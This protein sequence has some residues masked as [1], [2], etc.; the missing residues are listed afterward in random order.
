[1]PQRSAE[2]W[3]RIRAD[4]EAGR[5]TIAAIAAREGV[6]VASI[7]RQARRH[8]WRSRR[9]GDQGAAWRDRVLAELRWLAE[10]LGQSVTAVTSAGRVGPI[11]RP[12]HRPSRR[13]SGRP[14]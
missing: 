12:A 8:G 3:K 13:P 1:M 14:S 11:C 9:A 5:E 7:H 4:Y 2:D 10:E 6:N